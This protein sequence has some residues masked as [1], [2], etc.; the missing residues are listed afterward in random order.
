M[1][2]IFQKYLL[3]DKLEFRYLLT[4]LLINDTDDKMIKLLQKKSR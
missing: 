2:K 4:E 3:Y 1:L